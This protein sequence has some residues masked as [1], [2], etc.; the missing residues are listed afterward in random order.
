VAPGASAMSAQSNMVPC[1]GQEIF[2]FTWIPHSLDLMTETDQRTSPARRIRGLDAAERREQRR[3]AVLA[4]ALRLFADQGY[5]NTSIEQLCQEAFVSTRSFYD[6]FQGREDC[7]KALFR[8]L[9]GE[10]ETDMLAGLETIP[11]D[12]DTATTIL[13]DGL[14]RGLVSNPARA[15]VLLGPTRAITPDIEVIRRENREWA[16]SFVDGVWTRFGV[17]GDNHAIAIALIGG[18]F[19]IVTLW[20]IDG[21]PDNDESVSALAHHL[22]R[23]YRAVR[24]GLD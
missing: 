17:V 16:A 11:D 1:F 18:M 14:V 8:Q 19:D 21:D 24:R 15:R 22:G 4:A 5:L 9:T 6:L 2:F 3:Q 23:F 12:E 10:L 13:L 7:Y 20:L